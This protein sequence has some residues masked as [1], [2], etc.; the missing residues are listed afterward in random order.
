MIVIFKEM[1]DVYK[2]TYQTRYNFLSWCQHWIKNGCLISHSSW[3]PHYP[4]LKSVQYSNEELIKKHSHNKYMHQT[5][6]FFAFDEVDYP[7][8]FDR[9]TATK[10][11]WIAVPKNNIEELFE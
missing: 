4:K 5:K 9:K 11:E 8:F 7:Y 3:K 2:T 6:Q 10:G 1:K